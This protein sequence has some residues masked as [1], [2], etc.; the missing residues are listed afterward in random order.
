MI[1]LGGNTLLGEH[2]PWTIDEQRAVIETTARSVVDAIEAGYSVVLTHGNGPQVGNLMLQQE[3]A[4]ETPQLPLD[5]LVAETQAQIGYLLQQALDNELAGTTDFVTVVTQAVVDPADPA[6]ERPT[7][8][9]GPYYTEAEA[10]DRPF[11]TRTVSTGER[12]YRRVVPSPEPIEIV[13]AD[14]IERLVDR[15]DLVICAGGGGVPVVRD[16]GL[17][18]V[19]AV[20]DKDHATRLLASEIDAQR[21]VILTDVE[22]AYVDFGGPDQRPLRAVEVPELRAHLRNGEFG[23]G[24][25]RPKVRAC[26]QFVADGGEL[27]AITS[28]DRL[29]EALGGTAGTRVRA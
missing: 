8:P 26:L 22:Y 4:P 20:I 11:E 1:A 17:R 23:A 10:R 16:D 14:E 27:A 3:S 15:G 2:G 7:K 19:E 13:E 18:G 6:F 12:Q 25:M 5:V 21:L 29:D 24:S 9:I 28:P